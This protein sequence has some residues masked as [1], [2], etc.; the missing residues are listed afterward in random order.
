MRINKRENLL[1][2]NILLPFVYA[3]GVVRVAAEVC[4]STAGRG[5]DEQRWAAAEMDGGN[6]GR[7]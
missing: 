5:S 1:R 6:D 7:H 4:V 2:A 3:Y